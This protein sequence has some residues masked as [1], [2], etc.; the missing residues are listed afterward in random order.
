MLWSRKPTPVHDR[1]RAV[2]ID[3]TASRIR[4]EAVGGKSRPLTLDDP[5]AE[6]LLFVAGDRRTPEVGRAGFGICR[7]TPHLVCS[8]FLASVGQPR[9]WRIGRHTLI[10]ETALGLAFD[11]LRAPVT[12]ETDALA[13][14]LPAYLGPAQVTRATVAAGRS[15]LPLKGTAVGALALVADRAASLLTGKPAAPRP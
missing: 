8:N 4:A 2:G 7:K 6:L 12:A 9:E 10:A 5:D 1:A 14:A 13:M 3:V 15:K 11:K